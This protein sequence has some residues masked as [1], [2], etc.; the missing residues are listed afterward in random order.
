MGPKACR[1]CGKPITGRRRYYC[2]AA[3]RESYRRATL[4]P[5]AMERAHAKLAELRSEGA[6]PATTDEVL[7]RISRTQKKYREAQ[8]AWSGPGPGPGPMSGT[9]RT[10]RLRCIW[11][12]SST[13]DAVAGQDQTVPPE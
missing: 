9:A 2:N 12:T 8:A 11:R 5:K 4:Y 7:G 10:G 3:C 6:N 13:D 1:E